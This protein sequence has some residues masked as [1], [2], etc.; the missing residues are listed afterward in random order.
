MMVIEKFNAGLQNPFT[1]NSRN[2]SAK[3]G[4]SVKKNIC[5]VALN[6]CR[7]ETLVHRQPKLSM[8]I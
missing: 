4:R 1:L 3:L 8:T 5:H 6:A 7:P 2:M